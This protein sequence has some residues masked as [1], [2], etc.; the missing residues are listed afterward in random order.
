[1][2]TKLV[3]AAVAFTFLLMG[4][5]TTSFAQDKNLKQVKTKTETMKQEVKKTD[6]GVKNQTQEVKKNVDKTKE[7][8]KHL[9]T[10][11]VKDLKN[12]EKEVKSET[13]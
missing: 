6:E 9:K 5:N 13:K 4:I 1:M 12:K 11:K 7:K 2:K 8:V 10:H 3:A